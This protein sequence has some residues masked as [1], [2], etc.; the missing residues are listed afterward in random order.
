MQVSGET[1]GA[2]DHYLWK[3]TYRWALLTHRSKSGPWVF[4]RYF[5]KFNR[6]RQRPVTRTA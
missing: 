1:F 3:L 2:L 6:F 5:G 4:A